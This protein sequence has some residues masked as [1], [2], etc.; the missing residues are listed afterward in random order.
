MTV[1]WPASRTP[2]VAGVGIEHHVDAAIGI[3]RQDEAAGP[4]SRELDRRYRPAGIA[5]R[6][7][8]RGAEARAGGEAHAAHVDRVADRK[9][10]D[11]ID[12]GAAD[13]RG[14]LDRQRL[15]GHW[16]RNRTDSV[17]NMG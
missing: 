12:E 16:D 11:H 10:R 7:Q 13:Q 2:V 9:A 6:Q 4:D 14:G 15:A 5:E 8:V 1:C 17:T 3:P